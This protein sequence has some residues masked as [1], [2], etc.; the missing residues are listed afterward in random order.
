MGLITLNRA[1]LSHFTNFISYI[2]N[3]HFINV[4]NRKNFKFMKFKKNTLLHILFNLNFK[5]SK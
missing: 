1:Y 5:F 2:E 3:G 4:Q